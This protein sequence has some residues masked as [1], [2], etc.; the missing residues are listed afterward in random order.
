MSLGLS[1]G[2]V[3]RRPKSFEMPHAHCAHAMSHGWPAAFLRL[4]GAASRDAAWAPRHGTS[5]QSR[6]RGGLPWRAC[7]LTAGVASVGVPSLPRPSRRGGPFGTR[8]RPAG[9]AHVRDDAAGAAARRSFLTARRRGGGAG[10]GVVQLPNGRQC[11]SVQE[12]GTRVWATQTC[13]LGWTVKSIWARGSRQA[14]PRHPAAE[15]TTDVGQHKLNF[16]ALR[17]RLI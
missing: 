17:S 2:D 11:T 10:R 14:P 6:D 8:S 9:L 12:M 13:T 3:E 15:A 5:P 7:T 1:V 16:H 4:V